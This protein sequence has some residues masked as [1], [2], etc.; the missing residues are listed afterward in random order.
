M[1]LF[2]PGK[3]PFSKNPGIFCRMHGN[4]RLSEYSDSLKRKTYC[5]L[6]AS[7]IG[8]ILPVDLSGSSCDDSKLSFHSKISRKLHSCFPDVSLDLG[9]RTVLL[10][11]D[12]AEIVVL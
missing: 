4:K 3:N 6:N 7:F 5:F 2:T 11:V 1:F 9:L 8:I 12:Q 10:D